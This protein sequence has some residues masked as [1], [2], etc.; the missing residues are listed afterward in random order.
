MAKSKEQP[1]P[2]PQENKPAVVDKDNP[3][4]ELSPDDLKKV[5]G[6]ALVDYKPER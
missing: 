6:G 2:T 5:T 4:G 1:K 3:P